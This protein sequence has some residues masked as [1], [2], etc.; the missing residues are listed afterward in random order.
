[1]RIAYGNYVDIVAIVEMDVSLELNAL[2][3]SVMAVN[4]E[5]KL[6][7]VHLSVFYVNFMVLKGYFALRRSVLLPC[8]L[9]IGCPALYYIL[10]LK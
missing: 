3:V 9:K 6:E 8:F 2:L 10:C 4:D 7:Y 5:M 1:M